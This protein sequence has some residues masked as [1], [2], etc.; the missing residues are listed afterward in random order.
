MDVI[1]ILREISSTQDEAAGEA[2]SDVTIALRTGEKFRGLVE[3]SDKP[4]HEGWGVHIRIW[5]RV[6]G[7]GV[8]AAD[9]Q[10]VSDDGGCRE[11]PIHIPACSIAWVAFSERA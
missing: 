6:T 3:V 9:D 11:I 8:L 1:E 5:Q 7:G 10:V 2:S 4:S